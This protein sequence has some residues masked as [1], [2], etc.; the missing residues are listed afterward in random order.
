MPFIICPTCSGHGHHAQALGVINP[1]DFSSE[2][3][4]DYFSGKLDEPCNRCE[5]TGKLW[6]EVKSCSVQ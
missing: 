6:E 3:L 1:R 2:E 5:S 4:T